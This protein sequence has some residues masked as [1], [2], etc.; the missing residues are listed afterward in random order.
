MLFP[1]ACS[2]VF[3]ICRL[4]VNRLSV[5]ADGAADGNKLHVSAATVVVGSCRGW[6]FPC[7]GWLSCFAALHQVAVLPVCVAGRPSITRMAGPALALAAS[8]AVVLWPR[9]PSP[10]EGAGTSCAVLRAGCAVGAACAS[11]WSWVGSATGWPSPVAGAGPIPVVCT[12]AGCVGAFR[13][14]RTG[15][16]AAGVPPR[17][18]FPAAGTGP[19]VGLV[20]VSIGCVD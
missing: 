7:V 4:S 20:V 1:V 17:W 11:R 10:M 3:P 9:R 6:A 5:G 13:V 18:P 19:P 15:A 12:R 14:K 2:C 8:R 16:L